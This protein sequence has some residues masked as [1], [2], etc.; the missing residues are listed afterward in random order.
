MQ[1]L[2]NLEQSCNQTTEVKPNVVE[3]TSDTNTENHSVLFEDFY[4]LVSFPF[5]YITE[6]TI[7]NGSQQH[8]KNNTSDDESKNPLL[9]IFFDNEDDEQ[10]NKTDPQK[11]K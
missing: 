6:K 9:R 1:N 2:T 10:N 7:K 8:G 5:S 4:K 3:H 11:P